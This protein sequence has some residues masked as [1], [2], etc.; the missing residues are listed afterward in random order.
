M[1]LVVHGMAG[2]DYDAASI[3]LDVPSG[4]RVEA[5]IAV[6]RPGRV[7]DLEEKIREREVPSPRKPVAEFAFEGD[8]PRP[9]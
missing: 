8:F 1:G 4:F 3:T 2:F 9:D 5:M 7:E 6:G